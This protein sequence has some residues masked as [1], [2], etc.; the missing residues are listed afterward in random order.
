MIYVN[1][2]SYMRAST[3]KTTAD[4]LSD[5]LKVK[6][7]NASISGSSNDRIFRTTL[8]DLINL[9]SETTEKIIA[10]ISLSFIY[11]ISIWDPIGQAKRWKYSDDG[12]FACYHL[13]LSQNKS[14]NMPDHLKKYTKELGILFNPEAEMTKLLT[15]VEL[16]SAWCNYNKIKCI[17]FSGP[18]QEDV[19]DFNAP[20]IKPFYNSVM[21]NKNILNLFDF[22]FC[23]YCESQGFQGFDYQLYGKN[24]HHNEDAHEQF[25][26]FL[27][28]NFN[29]TN[30]I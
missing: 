17:I 6:T 29:L 7:I 10:I 5:K 15:N 30:E 1:G 18:T 4:Y 16:I 3:G 22:S 28:K 20:F 9:K 27:I 14:F 19:I 21:L 2:D 24:A 8:R 11:R 26:D 23:K 12:E 25:A 13:F